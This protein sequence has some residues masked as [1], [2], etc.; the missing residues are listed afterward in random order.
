[1]S[2]NTAEKA[3][4]VIGLINFGGGF[5]FAGTALFLAY[6]KMDFMLNHLK[7][8]RAVTSS[9]FLRNGGPWGNLSLMGE[10][11]CVFATPRLALRYGGASTDDMKNFPTGLRRVLITLYWLG[12]TFFIVMCALV[13]VA[14]LGLI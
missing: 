2:L 7:N 6:T 9:A 5:I 4:L 10:I 3:Y 13:G 12:W 1:M 14:E 8:C 11:M